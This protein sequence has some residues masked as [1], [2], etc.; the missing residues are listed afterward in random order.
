MQ[1]RDRGASLHGS[2]SRRGA[3]AS[4]EQRFGAGSWK[5]IRLL[6]SHVNDALRLPRFAKPPLP[7]AYFTFLSGFHF[8]EVHIRLLGR[9]DLNAIPVPIQNLFQSRAKARYGSNYLAYVRERFSNA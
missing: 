3:R 7:I 6:W 4:R 1:L 5:P 9:Q 8:L 2:H